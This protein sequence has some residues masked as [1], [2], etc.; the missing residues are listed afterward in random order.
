MEPG[1]IIVN[2]LIKPDHETLTFAKNRL[3]SRVYSKDLIELLFH[4]PYTK[5]QF[6]VAAGIA[7]RQ[8]A[9][10]YLKELEK[11]GVLNGHKVGKENLYLNVKLFR[12]LSA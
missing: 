2:P 1:V 3:P 12:L 4:Q 5:V 9:A 6:L 11:I 7:E 8:T 10:E